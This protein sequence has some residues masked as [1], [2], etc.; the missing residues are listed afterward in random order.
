MLPWCVLCV[1]IKAL[2]NGWPSVKKMLWAIRCVE[3]TYGLERSNIGKASGRLFELTKHLR[4]N[5]VHQSVPSYDIQEFLQDAKGAIFASGHT[6]MFKVRDHVYIHHVCHRD[7]V[8]TTSHEAFTVL[9]GKHV[10]GMVG[11]KTRTAAISLSSGSLRAC[12]AFS[13]A[14]LACFSGFPIKGWWCCCCSTVHKLIRSSCIVG[15]CRLRRS[16]FGPH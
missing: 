2:G 11:G 16:T 6:D 9:R 4:D 13:L 1:Q 7:M 14:R 15:V 10:A 3:R 12:S 5:H 8:G